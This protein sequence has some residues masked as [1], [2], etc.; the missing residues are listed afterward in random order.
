MQ[1][2]IPSGNGSCDTD[3]MARRVLAYWRARPANSFDAVTRAE[4]DAVLRSLSSTSP[5]WRAAIA[6]DAAAAIGIVLRLR[7]S[8]PMCPLTD[9]V[10]T[11]LLACAFKNAAAANVLSITLKKLPITCRNRLALSTS[12]SRHHSVLARRTAGGALSARFTKTPRI[13]S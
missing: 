5:E 10:M 2:E 4:I 12:W 3:R 11:I 8:H 7:P 9:L 6:G 1:N 13:T